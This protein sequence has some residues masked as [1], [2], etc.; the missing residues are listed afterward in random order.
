MIISER[1]FIISGGAG[2]GK[3]GCT[4]AIINYCVGENIPYIAIKLDQR[5]PHSTCEI[6]SKELGLSG[7]IVH[8]I[9]C[10]SKNEKAVIILDQLD[11]LRWTQA[12]SSESLSICMEL[13]RQVRHF[14]Q[15][16][17]HKIIIV[18]V[19]RAYDLENDNNIKS[20]FEN[21][22]DDNWIDFRIQNFS[23]NIVQKI[24][25]ESYSRLSL[26]LKRILQIPN[27]L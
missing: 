23:D 1:S 13:I 19:C 24:I 21:K 15:T 12:Y 4:E 6:W 2:Y 22:S 9:H 16:R 11:A 17:I 18:F 20:L 3:S 25:G 5:V 8:A 7:S 14:N 10:I 27:N 26:K